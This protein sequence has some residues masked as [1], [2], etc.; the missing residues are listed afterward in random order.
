MDE[1]ITLSHGKF[2]QHQQ[3]IPTPG[4]SLPADDAMEKFQHSSRTP[5]SGLDAISVLTYNI[6]F[7]G[8]QFEPAKFRP[9]ASDAVAGVDELGNSTFSDGQTFYIRMQA[10]CD[11]I[12]SNSPDIVCLQEVTPWGLD[13]LKRQEVLKM[14]YTFSPYSV[15]RYGVVVLVKRS[16]GGTPEF[17]QVELPTRMGRTLVSVEFLINGEKLLVC[18]AHFESLSNREVRREQLLAAARAMAG[19][20]SAMLMGDF[21]F[22]SYRNFQGDE[23]KTG[24]ENDVLVEALPDFIDLWPVLHNGISGSGENTLG[25]TFDSEANGNIRK[26]ERMRYDRI[27]HRVNPR[28]LVTAR[29]IALVGTRPIPQIGVPP[30]DHFGI[31]ARFTFADGFSREMG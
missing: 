6:W 11:L 12:V 21:N 17:R 2:D 10:V 24:L 20:P 15:G 16:F 30:S 29:S 23:D 27:L 28:G 22:C 31:L 3:I 13:I 7:H 8:G 19:Y 4:R 14:I 5:G 25:Y 26:P 1:P 9:A 18:T